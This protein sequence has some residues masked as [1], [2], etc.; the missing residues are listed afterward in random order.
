MRESKSQHSREVEES[1]KGNSK[2]PKQIRIL[3]AHSTALDNLSKLN[4]LKSK[5]LL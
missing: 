5:Q 1:L 3:K 4:S 2:N